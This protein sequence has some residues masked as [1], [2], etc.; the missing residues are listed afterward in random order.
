MAD[1]FFNIRIIQSGETSFD[2]SRYVEKNSI[3]FSVEPRLVSVV[4]TLD[5]VDHV[6]GGGLRQKLRFRFNPLTWVEAL[7]VLRKLFE[8]PV[9]TIICSGMLAPDSGLLYYTMRLSDASAEYLARCKFGM[10]DWYQLDEI[11]LVEL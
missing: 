4:R 6:A 9:L 2:L 10:Q 3:S 7:Q 1:T 5:G 8:T 11:E